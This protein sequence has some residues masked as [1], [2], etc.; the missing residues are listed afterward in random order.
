VPDAVRPGPDDD[1]IAVTA[2]QVRDVITRLVTAGHGRDGD[3]PILVI[4]DAGDDLARLAWLLADRPAQVPGRLRSDRVRQLS[5]PPRQP[6]TR[7]HGGELALADP[8]T[9][10]PVLQAGPGLDRPQDPRPGRC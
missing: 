5:A 3:P 4:F 7:E 6:R 9:S 1:D 2:A 10:L 8:A